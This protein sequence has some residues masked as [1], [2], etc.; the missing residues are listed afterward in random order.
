MKTPL[1]YQMV[2][3]DS[4]ETSLCNCLSF[5]FERDEMPLELLKMISAYSNSCYDKFGNLENNELSRHFMYYTAG[6]I[7]TFAKEKKIPLVAKYYVG[8]DV[9]L[10]KI[11]KCLLSGGCVNLKAHRQGARHFV[12]IT[13]MDDEYMYIFDPYLRLNGYYLANS[14]IAIANDNPF[15]FNRKVRIE[16]FISENRVELALGPEE[17]RE[18]ILL[19]RDDAIL[20]REFD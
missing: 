11:R 6:W 14:G 8:E 9:D 10:L 1:R 12:T 2:E 4:G 5:L 3:R 7:R 13:N 20:Q 18:A 15:S 17:E 16:H 19:V